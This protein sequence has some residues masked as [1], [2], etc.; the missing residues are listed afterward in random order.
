MI[1]PIRILGVALA[2][3][4]CEAQP[5]A[6]ALSQQ[7]A[8]GGVASVTGEGK[9]GLPEWQGYVGQRIDALNTVDLPADARVM[10]PTTPATMDFQAERLNIAVDSA[11]TIVRVYCG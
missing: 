11:D 6:E 9:C 7:A 3:G 10:F 8:G 4:A 2:L 5:D 1:H